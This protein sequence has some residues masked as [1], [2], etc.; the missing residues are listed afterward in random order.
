MN[1]VPAGVNEVVVQTCWYVRL[2]M[3]LN[4]EMRG[5]AVH[6]CIIACVN[7]GN[8]ANASVILSLEEVLGCE[9]K[10]LRHRRTNEGN[11]LALCGQCLLSC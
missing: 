9:L 8:Q 4:A 7:N 11:V 3:L 10:L 1:L 5:V 6:V 2:S